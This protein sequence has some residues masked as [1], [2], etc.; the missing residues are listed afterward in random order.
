YNIDDSAGNNN[1]V[2]DYSE[3]IV[4]DMTVNNV[5]SDEA[6]NV[7]VT[8]SSTD[9]YVT[10]IDGT[11][12]FGNI[13]AGNLATVIGAFSFDVA[14]NI[15]DEH[16]INFDLEAVGQATWES[17]FS[18]DAHAPVLT[19]ENFI[20]NDAAGNNNGRLD[21]GETVT[22]LI[23]T[24]NEGSATSPS[25][26]GTL[27]CTEPL[28]TIEVETYTLGEIVAGGSVD[29]VYTVTAD[30]GIPVGSTLNFLYE[31]V[32]GAYSSQN[33]FSI[34]VGLIVED[35]ETNNF[36]SFEW[37][38][39]G[40]ANWLIATNPYEG[41]Y[42]AQSGDIGNYQSSSLYLQVNVLSA[43]E[44]SF[45]KKVSSEGGWDYLRFYVD[46][47]EIDSWSGDVA[48]SQETYQITAGEH[49]FKW[50]YEKD[51]SVSTGSDCGWIDYIVFPPIGMPPIGTIE[52]TVT[53]TG[54]S[55]NVQDVVV[56]ADGFSTN[57][58]ASGD[59]S[60]Q[61]SPGTYDVIA[62][63]DCYEPVTVAGVLV[64][65]DITT[66]GIDFTLYPLAVPTGLA[67]TI[68]DFN[69]VHLEWTQPAASRSIEPSTISINNE[70]ISRTGIQQIEKSQETDESRDLLGYKI[71]RDDV[72]IHE[73]TNSTTTT[74]DDL[75]LDAGDYDYHVT[76]I[77]DVGESYPSNIEPVTIIL[78]AP[79]NPQAGSQDQD[80]LIT[81][82]APAS[83]ALSH[84]KVYQNLVQIANNITETSYLHESVPTGT[85]TYNIKAVYDGGYE[86]A[87]S[88][89]AVVEHDPVNTDDL[90]IPIKTELCGNYPNPFNPTTTINFALSEAG[91][92]TIEVYNIKGEKVVT[93]Q[94]GY[95]EAAY[96]SVVWNGKDNSGNNVSSGIYF[97]KMRSDGRY[98]STRKMILLK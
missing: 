76:A 62:E 65:Q 49:T 30:P 44:L 47:N 24:A 64:E 66:S 96:H 29:A 45:Y 90:L 95:L 17:S 22:V 37:Q 89:D 19:S 42:C 88:A 21:P 27:T 39:G 28:I 6:I 31:V 70:R 50:E 72:M 32:A 68:V 84:Y 78:P 52:G 25:A 20:I 53:L 9:P 97:Y 35:F 63:L 26:I 48:W 80:I 55:G 94:N 54:G 15:P 36:Q 2:A 41:A 13:P 81:W 1:G 46:N 69:D 40:D 93:L 83:R 11:E 82:D 98:T 75:A 4:L 33:N 18:I 91:N 86:S 3:S 67:G 73:I 51:S 7:V 60:F 59:Y 92:V 10:I 8:I 58:D 43:G 14:D 77:Y 74:Y 34:V 5:G 16:I 23:P 56:S 79:Q 71:Y 87:M 12:N 57:P 61:V 85:Y 38:F